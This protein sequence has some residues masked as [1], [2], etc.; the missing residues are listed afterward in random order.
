MRTELAFYLPARF[1]PG[2]D[3]PA[4]EPFFWLTVSSGQCSCPQP[5]PH[6]PARPAPLAS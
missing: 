3:A 6:D 4:T 1:W 5:D 2:K